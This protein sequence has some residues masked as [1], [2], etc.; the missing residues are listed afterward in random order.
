MSFLRSVQQ[1]RTTRFLVRYSTPVVINEFLENGS[2]NPLEYFLETLGTLE[3]AGLDTEEASFDLMSGITISAPPVTYETLTAL[4]FSLDVE[5]GVRQSPE[6]ELI[7]TVPTPDLPATPST[8]PR[9]LI[10]PPTT[11]F[12]QSSAVTLSES[13][14]QR[15]FGCLLHEPIRKD[16]IKIKQCEVEELTEEEQNNILF[17]FALWITRS[18]GDALLNRILPKACDL[19]VVAKTVFSGGGTGTIL[20]FIGCRLLKYYIFNE[21]ASNVTT[22]SIGVQSTIPTAIE[23]EDCPPVAVDN[24]GNEFELCQ[25]EVDSCFV[26]IRNLRSNLPGGEGYKTQLQII[27][28]DSPNK[29]NDLRQIS[30][31]SPINPE[32]I[33][34]DLILEALYGTIPQSNN[35]PFKFGQVKYEVNVSPYG[36]IRYYGQYEER[37]YQ[38]TKDLFQRISDLLIEGIADLE[39]FRPSDR[40]RKFADLDL[41]PVKALL[42][43]FSN[44][45]NAKCNRWDLRKK[46]S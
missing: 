3:D 33:T 38:L 14:Q 46:D 5:I 13:I 35:I 25:P 29:L 43:D 27:F 11:R 39:S 18:V 10:V 4:D 41:Y 45:G 7:K 31:P 22:S 17:T 32:D 30:I 24:S 28:S 23:F 12:S 8:R 40:T 42:F 19:S 34:R 1:T 44:P 26:P 37:P 9:G 20:T 21:I 6:Y 15:K 36:Y 16:P 2:L